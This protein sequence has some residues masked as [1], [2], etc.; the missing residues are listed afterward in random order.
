MLQGA[1]VLLLQ[2]GLRR[3]VASRLISETCALTDLVED[4]QANIVTFIVAKTT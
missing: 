2:Q 4:A 3:S 1:V